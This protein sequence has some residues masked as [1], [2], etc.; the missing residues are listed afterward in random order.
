M[1]KKPS[2]DLTNKVFGK[3]KVIEYAGS[4]K[5]KCQCECG[6][7]C[8]KFTTHLVGEYVKSCGI[9]IKNTNAF[10]DM[11]G[12]KIGSLYIESYAGDSR[13]NCICDCG[14]KTVVRGYE[15]RKEVITNCR[16]CADNKR[17]D[18]LTGK[19]FGSW[20]VL[21]YAG[22]KQWKCKCKKCGKISKVYS[23][24]LKSGKS[25]EC[26]DCANKSKLNDL[27][28]KTF[29]QW[30]VL[31]YIGNQKYKCK[32]S[33][34]TISEVLVSNLISGTSTK[35]TSCAKNG[36]I[37][38]T[39]KYKKRDNKGNTSRVDLTGKHFGELEAIEY[40]GNRKWRCKCSCGSIKDYN[41]YALT[42]GHTKS[43]GHSTGCLKDMTG[44]VINGIKFESYI[45]DGIWRCKCHCGK[46]FNT[47]ARYVRYGSIKSCG[48]SQGNRKYDDLKDKKFGEWTALE[49]VG[50]SRWK[51]QC[52]CGNIDIVGAY[53]LKHG[54][55]T[56]CISPLHRLKDLTGQTFGELTVEKYLGKNVYKCNCSCGNTKNVLATNLKN[57]STKSCGCK[58]NGI[59][60]YEED[61]VAWLKTIT[62]CKIVTSDRSILSGKE[63]DIYIPDK[64]IAIEFNGTFWHSD[65][66]KDKYYHQKKTIECAK[67]NIRLIHIFEHEWQDIEKQTKIKDIIVDLLSDNKQRVYARE[68]DIRTVEKD[69][70]K[71]FLDKYHLQGYAN[72]SI[73]IGLYY[74]NELISLM[75]FGKPRFNHTYDYEIIRLCTK[76]H[77][78]IVGGTERMFKY[79]LKEHIQ[80]SVLT[81]SDIS[82]FTGNIYTK[83]GFKV[84]KISEPN[85]VWIEPIKNIVVTRYQT[86][87]QKL[88][89]EITDINESMTETEIMENLGFLKIYDCGNLVMSYSN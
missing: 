71:E 66:Y 75:T 74:K 52:S 87:K 53:Q 27:T 60:H 48:C 1:P 41:T 9:C 5:W 80:S 44:Q 79:F 88:L 85:Y 36:L 23:Y 73:N 22:D 39:P 78:N 32:C 43:C 84:D 50:K 61:I 69:D 29:G 63:I 25:T 19:I 13:W 17:L 11:T 37:G 49:Y 33:C 57:G 51:C 35:C 46:E 3:L 21:E 6:N 70:A 40:V 20:E 42:S 89:R 4:G 82:K 81:Y 56:R 30:L 31:E 26:L 65:I 38:D 67:K 10:K 45:G 47:L 24:N 12:Q 28:N 7:I 68:T 15:L 55:S 16:K 2:Q 83:L 34:G 77:L 76:S 72:S 18:N 59:S 62:Q 58:W 14:N 64:H 54:N 8:E 86:Q